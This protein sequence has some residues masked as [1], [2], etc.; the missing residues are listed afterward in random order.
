M[1]SQLIEEQERNDELSKTISSLVDE[2]SHLTNDLD[3]LNQNFSSLEDELARS[4]SEVQRL[5]QIETNQNA[6]LG[7][8]RETITKHVTAD[9]KQKRE[10]RETQQELQGALS[11]ITDLKSEIL[12]AETKISEFLEALHSQEDENKSVSCQLRETKAELDA[13]RRQL[14]VMEQREKDAVSL[15]KRSKEE[16][17]RVIKDMTDKMDESCAFIR[18]ELAHNHKIELDSI[19]S[20]LKRL[21]EENCRMR[22]ELNSMNKSNYDMSMQL[23]KSL[24]DLEDEKMQHEMLKVQMRDVSEVVVWLERI[25]RTNIWL[26]HAFVSHQSTQDNEQ[27]QKEIRRVSEKLS[28]LESRSDAAAKAGQI[29]R[30]SLEKQ[31]SNAKKSLDSEIQR[32]ATSINDMEDSLVTFAKD[33]FRSK[34]L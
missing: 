27:L 20:D 31:L 29:E 13:S 12:N 34:R 10:L 8:L 21:T 32:H 30:E 1:T 4:Q 3:R 5:K 22:S 28:N 17:A 25:I 2:N 7:E 6:V 19:S 24:V 14:T 11:K 26:I 16:T 15:A 9:E 33:L 18:S 23:K